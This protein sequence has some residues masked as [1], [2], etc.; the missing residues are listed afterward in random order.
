M[1]DC[2]QELT[3][4]FQEQELITDYDCEAG[5]ILDIPHPWIQYDNLTSVLNTVA[6]IIVARMDIARYMSFSVGDNFAEFLNDADMISSIFV[7]SNLV[8]M[9]GITYEYRIGERRITF[10]R[11]SWTTF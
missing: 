2:L 9:L 5:G 10:Y 7:L 4:F 8:Q 3:L 1:S 11:T 6:K